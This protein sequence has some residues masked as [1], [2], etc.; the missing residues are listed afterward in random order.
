MNRK[1]LVIIQARLGSTR[2]P[3]KVLK[4]I[5][6]KTVIEMIVDRIS[7]SK[8]IDNLVVAT[9]DKSIDKKLH[10]FL[11]G[12]NINVFLGSEK[13]VLDR[14]YKVSKLFSPKYVVRICGDC[15]F[16]DSKLLDE[17]IKKIKAKNYDY[18]SNINPPTRTYCLP[19]LLNEYA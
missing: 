19:H 12:K 3:N 10:K 15:P 8:Y 14:F 18:V 5:G 6:K 2:F 1:V 7:K 11:R 4:K 16:V 9:T 13:N 17:M